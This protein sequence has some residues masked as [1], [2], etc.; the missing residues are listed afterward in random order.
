MHQIR[1]QPKAKLP[2]G[3]TPTMFFSAPERYGGQYAFVPTPREALD[4][5]REQIPVTREDAFRWVDDEVQVAADK[6]WDSLG[7]PSITL[8][9]A[10]EVFVQMAGPLCNM[11]A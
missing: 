3:S 2:S 9:S 8:G 7:H 1:K 6:A 11:Y 4:E 10:W 5:L